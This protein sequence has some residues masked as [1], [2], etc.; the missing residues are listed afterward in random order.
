MDV[1]STRINVN[2]EINCARVVGE[3]VTASQTHI[4]PRIAIK[5][6][7][8]EPLI[9]ESDVVASNRVGGAE[10][11]GLARVVGDKA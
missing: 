11:V 4:D 6:R 7:V 2:A 10:R 3:Y 9:T 8:G 5:C 1:V